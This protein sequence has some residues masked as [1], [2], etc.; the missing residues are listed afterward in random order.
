MNDFIIG[1]IRTWVP[2]VVGF[3]VTWLARNLNVVID[4]TTSAELTMFVSTAVSGA[5]YLA[6]RI[7]AEKVPVLGVLLGYNQKPAYL[8]AAN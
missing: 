7:A 1:H 6:V 8:E 4:E 2:M 5:Y 3:G